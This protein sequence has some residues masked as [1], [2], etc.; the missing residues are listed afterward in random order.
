MNDIMNDDSPG[1]EP[2]SES[3]ISNETISKLIIFAED[4][5]VVNDSNID[6]SD[7]LQSIIDNY[8]GIKIIIPSSMMIKKT[9]KYYSQTII[10]GI[11]ETRGVIWAGENFVGNNMFEPAIKT[12][13]AV[14][15][16]EFLNLTLVDKAAKNNGRGTTSQING[17][18][19]IG[20]LS[21][22]IINIK[23]VRLNSTIHCDIGTETQHTMRPYIHRVNGSNVNWHILFEPT[24]ND[25]FAY[26]DI[27]IS[28]LKSSGSCL[29]GV[30]IRDTDG[31]QINGAVLFP[32]GGIEISGHYLNLTNIHPFEPKA[33]LTDSRIPACISIV[34]RSKMNFSRYVNIAN[35][36][37][38]FAGRL[39]DTTS[40]APPQ[41]NNGAPSV[42]ME[43]VMNFNISFTSNNPS[44]EALKLIN[45][46]N[47][48]FTV[49]SIDSNAQELGSGKLPV[50]SYDTV[51]M[52]KC[53]LIIGNIT[54]FSP[55]R[56]YAIFM[57]D[58]CDSNH[59][60]GVISNGNYAGEAFRIP[61]N[62]KTNA[63]EII[64]EGG[65]GIIRT[66][67]DIRKLR[68][69]LYTITDNSAT[70]LTPDIGDGDIVKFQNNKVTNVTDI[71][72]VNNYKSVLITIADN[73]ATRLIDVNNGG[74]FN[75][76]G[77]NVMGRG[78]VFRVYRDDLSGNLIRY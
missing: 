74:R 12:R 45:C 53:S 32:N 67:R 65:N 69:E 73:N 20:T 30:R 22:K 8:K 4:L 26:G 76:G 35:T 56:R 13:Q 23:G 44:M 54:D 61:S 48:T 75:L 62:G 17:I 9:I 28:D 7:A 3:R 49:S 72:G 70:P 78:T 52:E 16:P 6:S 43:N 27:Y 1:T 66:A 38:G 60:T 64:Q 5:G 2:G 34:P 59:V 42:R 21:A 63:V 58:S 40:G 11:T 36:A 71:P 37:C 47:G 51:H 31:L 39:A 41:S 18:E 77:T 50:G 15:E 29:N 46:Q 10:S 55:G 19:L 68:P 25:R 14:H 57:D 24:L 33:P